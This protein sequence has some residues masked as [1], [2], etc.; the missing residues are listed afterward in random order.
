MSCMLRIIGEKF[1]VDNFIKKSKI[2]PLNIF[3]KGEPKFKTKPRGQKISHSGLS[4]ETSKADF[5]N[6]SQQIKDTIN[7]LNKNKLKLKHLSK[8]KGI[9]F[10][11]LDFGID[12][13]IDKEKILI[14][15]ELLP[16]KLL[17]IAGECGLDIEISIYPIDL[18][19]LVL[20][21]RT[22]K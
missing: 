18:H 9:D 12:L 13:R 17:K 14:Q 8:T 2:E 16:N 15:S 19:D 11:T 6:L 21:L 3:H 7:Y 10:A 4:I 20:K 5:N 1:D 22:K